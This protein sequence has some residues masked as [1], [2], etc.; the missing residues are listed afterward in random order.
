MRAPI[1]ARLGVALV[2]LAACARAPAAGVDARR[3]PSA[4][5]LRATGL[6]GAPD[7]TVHGARLVPAS[8]DEAG[9]WGS[10]PGGGVR[11]IVAGLRIV[12]SPA[13]D[14]AAAR[15]RLPANPSSVT[16]LPERLGGGFLMALGPHLWSAQ[17]WLGPAAPIF[18]M[19]SAITE[20]F[21]GL[22][23]AYVRS[24]QGPLVALD[25]RTG[26]SLDLGPLPASPRVASIAALDAWRALAVADLR[27]AVLTLD[28]GSSWRPVALPIEPLRASPLDEAFS[29]AG[30]DRARAPQW[31]SVLPDGQ[32]S[33]FASSPS[34]VRTVRPGTH[35]DAGAPLGARPLAAAV[36]DGWPLS[37][38]TA[39]VARD[40]ALARV[41]VADGSLVEM[42]ADAFS[43]KPARCHPLSLAR[44]ADPGAFGFVCGEPRG[45]T[46]VLRWDAQQSRLIELRRFDAP[47]EV[48]A[49]GSGCLAVRGRCA[50]Q[51]GNGRKLTI[52]AR[53]DHQDWCLM[54]PDG[55]WS[56]M[57]LSGPG[58]DGAR[59]VVLS[60]RRVALVRPPEGGDL[61]TA[62]LTLTD[63]LTDGARATH[64]PLRDAAGPA[65]D[66]ARA[67][68]GHL[69]GRLRGA[70]AGRARRLD[71]RGGVDPRRR[72]HAR[73]RAPRGEYIR[74]AGAP[75]AAG[76]WAFGWTASRGGFETMDGGMSWTKEIGS[77]RAD[78]RAARGAPPALRADRL[79]DRGVVAR[80]LGAGGRAT[81]CPAAAA[82]PSRDPAGAGPRPGLRIARRCT[83]G[84]RRGPR[85]PAGP[86]LR[87]RAPAPAD[88]Q[89]CP[90]LRRRVEL[91]RGL[92]AAA[93]RWS[94]GSGD[95]RPG[96]WA[97]RSTRRTRSSEAS[98]PDR[99][100][101]ATH[102]ARASGTGIP[103]AATGKCAGRGPGRA[104]RAT[105]PEERS[106]AVGVVAVGESRGR[107]A[108]VREPDG[109]LS[110]SGRSSQATTPTTLSSSSAARASP[111]ASLPARARSRSRPSRPTALP[112][113]CG[114]PMAKCS[115][116]SRERSGAMAAGISPRLRSPASPLRLSS[117]SSTAPWVASWAGSPGWRRSPPRQGD[118]CAGRA[119]ETRGGASS[120][121]ALARRRDRR[122]ATGRF[123]GLDASTRSRGLSETPSRSRRPTC[124]TVQS[125]R[126]RETTQDGSSRRA[127]RGRST[128]ASGQRGPLACKA[129]WLDYGYR[130]PR[131]ASTVLFATADS[132]AAHE[133]GAV[134]T[135]RPGTPA[136]GARLVDATVLGERTRARLRCQMATR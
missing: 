29:V 110:P 30:F 78:R 23:R 55:D 102:G 41:R 34:P 104:R 8:L 67:P 119:R 17:T 65:R 135:P 15:D 121:L 89:P 35:P 105:A 123:L 133:D 128:C 90:W 98:D 32:A 9:V 18:S 111:P 77:A 42:Q 117:G 126:A 62:R 50:P 127:I 2:A 31:W 20:V 47:R 76:R 92:T 83:S 22:D 130:A 7:P 38:G 109:R 16:E 84:R 96:S 53:P 44:A 54:G 86:G 97:S 25:P 13:G 19:P 113:R 28:A 112:S 116:S 87:R 122:R 68:L 48:L 131:R 91:G 115:P 26:A 72:D 82:A 106:S 10:E 70:P 66:R 120:P 4:A 56:E 88:A 12:S 125:R 80:R 39:L 45:T 75:V 11:A 21:V 40:G 94:P 6:H 118:S 27:G 57:H 108:R 58:V 33:W 124:P 60:S 95:L 36:E 49:S 5:A 51:D 99:S 93:V 71:R 103:P 14:V 81:S 61:S 64:L 107:R 59:L 43:L 134:A 100:R 114:A 101:G 132:K 85:P 24:A 3:P 129:R 46:L 1:A 136:E 74:D 63:G 73:R 37:D 69:D 52:S 79:R